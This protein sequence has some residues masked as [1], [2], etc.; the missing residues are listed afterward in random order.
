[1]SDDLTEAGVSVKLE[2]IS[3]RKQLRLRDLLNKRQFRADECGAPEEQTPSCFME[4]GPPHEASQF[5]S[6]LVIMRQMVHGN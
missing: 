6:E 5:A 2:D 3:R 4:S 1:M